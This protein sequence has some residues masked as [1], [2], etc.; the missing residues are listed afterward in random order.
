MYDINI[1][2]MLFDGLL[3]IA[4]LG[5]WLAWLKQNQQQSMIENKLSEAAAQL[6]DATQ[7]LDQALGK[8]ADLKISDVSTQKKLEK[9]ESNSHAN[10]QPVSE[11][12]QLAQILRMQREGESPEDIAQKL[13]TPLAQVK[14]LLMLSSSDPS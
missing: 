4:V 6:Q 5:L 10:Q 7:L 11:D 9:S 8:I 3:I 2:A 1:L 13:D 14:L 12:A